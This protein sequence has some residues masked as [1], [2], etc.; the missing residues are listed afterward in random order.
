MIQS[1]IVIEAREWK[2]VQQQVS[3]YDIQALVDNQLESEE[4]RRVR[5]QIERDPEAY[6][7][8]NELLRQNELLKAWWNQ[9]KNCH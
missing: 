3:A 6:R 8:Y 9:F 2:M 4:A 7:V 5:A 1:T